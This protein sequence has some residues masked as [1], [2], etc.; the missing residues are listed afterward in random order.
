MNVHRSI[1]YK[2][3]NMKLAPMSIIWRME[4]SLFIAF[5]YIFTAV[6]LVLCPFH[7]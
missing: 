7:I 5:P 3:R 6:K 2:S 4:K 1:I